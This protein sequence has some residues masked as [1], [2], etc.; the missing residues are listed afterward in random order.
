MKYTYKSFGLTIPRQKRPTTT[1]NCR[2]RNITSSNHPLTK[3]QMS[4]LRTTPLLTLLTTITRRTFTTTSR[5]MAPTQEWMVILPD[6]TGKLAERNKV[7][8]YVPP[9]PQATRLKLSHWH[10]D[11]I[12]DTR[13]AITSNI[14]ALTSNPDSWFLVARC[15]RSQFKK[16][17]RRR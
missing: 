15:W 3:E 1:F 14:Q 10:K 2:H 4:F 8:A 7:R 12:A 9:P 17:L 11:P 16:A 5:A 6:Y 13:T